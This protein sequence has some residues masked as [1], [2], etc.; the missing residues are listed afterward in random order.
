MEKNSY[1]GEEHIEHFLHEHPL[2]LLQ[3]HRDKCCKICTQKIHGPVYVCASSSSSC[4]FYL[5]KSCGDLPQEIRHHPV[6]HPGHS[7][8]L[9]EPASYSWSW[10][11]G[12]DGCYS[13]LR[14]FVYRCRY[15]NF[16]LHSDCAQYMT[17]TVKFQGHDQHL[18]TLVENMPFEMECK[19]CLFDISCTFFLRCVECNVNFHVQCGPHPLPLTVVDQHHSHP[20]SL[21]IPERL[22]ND[23]DEDF[24]LLLHCDT[25]NK[26]RNP[27]HPFYSCAE[28]DYS[29][30]VRCVITEVPRKPSIKLE[31]H[32]HAVIYMEELGGNPKCRANCKSTTR[33]V[34]YLRC[35]RCKDFNIH[36]TCS[37][38]PQNIKHWSHPHSLKLMN[39]F[40]DY[41]Y[42]EQMCDIC[43]T[44]RDPR[45]FVY[46]CAKC[47]FVAEF[48]C[49]FHEV[50]V[51]WC[52]F[53]I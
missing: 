6:H 29:V 14:G 8:I 11:H 48:E 13:P 23:D 27:K 44:K 40:V 24:S 34:P 10:M 53:F 7:L 18:L 32:D 17:P 38:L 26:E 35:V 12:C 30:H 21:T 25:C 50:S 42:D 41:N 9:R 47:Y 2:T 20:L 37:P 39:N 31:S 36:F 3:V 15:C 19:A 22:V 4:E 51:N 43:E 5:H 33:Q 16:D 49:V 52:L 45:D 46:Y 28:C 1:E